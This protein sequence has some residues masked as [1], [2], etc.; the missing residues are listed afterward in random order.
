MDNFEDR[1]DFEDGIEFQFDRFYYFIKSGDSLLINNNDGK[2]LSCYRQAF[3][4]L[5]RIDDKNITPK[6][7]KLIT[8][9]FCNFSIALQRR[10][11]FD[12]AVKGFMNAINFH[13]Q[14]NIEVNEMLMQKIFL[15][16][17]LAQALINNGQ[18][19][20]SIDVYHKALE[21]HDIIF[22]RDKSIKSVNQK[23]EIMKKLSIAFVES[24]QIEKAIASF[25]GTLTWQNKYPTAKYSES[26]SINYV[27]LF[28]N[29]ANCYLKINKFI[30]AIL[31]Y[32]DGLSFI[33]TLDIRDNI[34][35][36]MLKFH[37][38]MYSGLAYSKI[39]ESEKAYRFF[40]EAKNWQDKNGLLEYY[41]GLSGRLG[42]IINISSFYISAGKYELAIEEC[43]FGINLQ[44][45]NNLDKENEGKIIRIRLLS[46]IACSYTHLKLDEVAISNANL[47]LNYIEENKLSDSDVCR[48]TLITILLNRGNSY[49]NIN[50]IDRAI[51]DYEN[52]SSL[53]ENGS[54]FDS[55]HDK[56]LKVSLLLNYSLANMFKGSLDKALSGFIDA[57]DWQ[58]KNLLADA[59]ADADKI[60]RVRLYINCAVVYIKKGLFNK[61]IDVFSEGLL[62]HDQHK[63][64]NYFEGL[65]NKHNIYAGRGDC[66]IHCLQYKSALT[67]FQNS[68]NCIDA[69]NVPDSYIT[70]FHRIRTLSKMAL[71]LSLT[72]RYDK[73]IS[74]YVDILK[75]QFSEEAHTY[76][77]KRDIASNIC[78]MGDAYAGMKKWSDAIRLYNRG[79][80]YHTEHRLDESYEGIFERVFYCLNRA[81]CY[82]NCSDIKNSI[83]DNLEALEYL[84][85]F[86]YFQ[87]T[88]WSEHIHTIGQS[89]YQHMAKVDYLT[90]YLQPVAAVW[91][92]RLTESEHTSDEE[93]HLFSVFMRQ[94]L[95]TA[96]ACG[97]LDLLPNIFAILHGRKTLDIVLQD[98][99][100]DTDS[101]PDASPEQPQRQELRMLRAEIQKT[102]MQI[103]S[104]LKNSSA[105]NS[106]D[107]DILSF[108]L[109]LEAQQER[110]QRQRQHEKELQQQLNSL[111]E[112]HSD[113]IRQHPELGTLSGLNAVTVKALREKLAVGEG[114]VILAPQ[115]TP[116]TAKGDAELLAYVLLK[117]GINDGIVITV[118]AELSILSQYFLNFTLPGRTRVTEEHGIEIEIDAIH[119]SESEVEICRIWRIGQQ[120]TN[121]TAET[122]WTPEKGTD[123]M[124]HLFW[125][126][127]MTELTQQNMLSQSE[128][129]AIHWHIAVMDSLYT[130]PWRE[131]APK[132]CTVHT[133]LPFFLKAHKQTYSNT[134][135]FVLSASAASHLPL[136][137]GFLP[138]VYFEQ[139]FLM[140]LWGQDIPEAMMHCHEQ[141]SP[142]GLGHFS[143]HGSHDELNPMSSQ[144]QLHK[145]WT[146]GDIL[147][148][149]STPH[150]V[151]L[152][153][154]LAGRSSADSDGDPL[155]LVSVLQLRNS[156]EIV[157][158][159]SNVPDGAIAWFGILLNWHISQQNLTMAEAV[160]ECQRIFQRAA[161]PQKFITYIEQDNRLESVLKRVL[162]HLVVAQYD[163]KTQ[164][165]WVALAEI[166]TPH[167]NFE[168]KELCQFIKATL[169]K[170]NDHDNASA[171]CSY[172][173]SMV[174][175]KGMK[176]KVLR[177]DFQQLPHVIRFFGTAHT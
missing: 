115:W 94:Y 128:A 17:N 14:L 105:P 169:K 114:L 144:L 129:K 33:N 100:A 53:L 47:A 164:N 71:I 68:I 72:K 177:P 63:L 175:L 59:D 77:F 29:R 62:F 156:R 103:S 102:K 22:E 91:P 83:N 46:I 127:L 125:V 52:A 82:L 39:G 44:I 119:S 13:D 165:N 84:I 50:D 81:D 110:D 75:F 170:K 126:P 108:S 171:L 120:A 7:F 112:R 97:R 101:R 95:S 109:S 152:S 19:D 98:L 66:Y 167:E 88:D 54:V 86:W 67:D 3:S 133:A 21:C 11:Y 38:L 41:E 140:E 93:R 40:C 157:G 145:P 24:N 49:F 118:S 42:L 30:E 123:D 143:C 163:L 87:H 6:R 138:G 104:I 45:K 27:E 31:D 65:L 69:E 51:T 99:D 151:I 58:K 174:I 141:E 92:R 153:A 113:L 96:H 132:C 131:T 146:A 139:Q 161:W 70:R 80:T 168:I 159:L 173:I 134:T 34:S 8:H 28:I 172:A 79:I 154:C 5:S 36:K 107:S 4:I 158:A 106:F 124:Q 56:R 155:G 121:T 130:L 60:T 176:A 9:F 116:D 48:S 73:A 78:R 37:F 2:A 111:L 12:E 137:Q 74:M 20:V 90:G 64:D 10:G 25:S 117:E 150:A 43:N 149:A 26:G 148:S 166:I 1:I 147:R 23:I 55:Y 136:G 76:E 18:V 142:A 16:L 35:F 61:A 85:R 89:L 57:L 122:M 162:R 160:A 135:A 32:D 15:F